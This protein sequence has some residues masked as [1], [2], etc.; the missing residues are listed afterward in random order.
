MV[1]LLVS[2]FA[3]LSLTTFAQDVVQNVSG[4]DGRPGYSGSSGSGFSGNGAP[5]SQPSPGA[6]AKHLNVWVRAVEKVR[7]Q[8]AQC[9]LGDA[10]GD[11]GLRLRESDVPQHRSVQGLLDG[12]GLLRQVL[13]HVAARPTLF[14]RRQPVDDLGDQSGAGRVR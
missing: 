10:I 12:P 8:L 4:Q 1:R 11:G 14:G 7:H 3:L 13:L 5:A 9:E 2:F 6:H